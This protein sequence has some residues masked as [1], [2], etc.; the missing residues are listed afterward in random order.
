MVAARKR[1]G[2]SVEPYFDLVSGAGFGLECPRVEA[3][4]LHLDSPGGP[5]VE[6]IPSV[7]RWPP[8]ASVMGNSAA[9][10]DA[11]T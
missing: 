8:R 9:R 7:I 5:D 3:G 11:G 2:S 1:C 4:I 10:A 6:P